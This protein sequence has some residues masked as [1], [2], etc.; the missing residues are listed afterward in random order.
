MNCMGTG[1]KNA[2]IWGQYITKTLFEPTGALVIMDDIISGSKTVKG[3]IEIFLDQLRIC[4]KHGI[5]VNAKSLGVCLDEIKANGLKICGKGTVP[6]PQTCT[7][8]LRCDTRKM[9]K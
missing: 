8:A 9:T 3:A 5:K 4:K 6:L 7:K 2:A 1:L